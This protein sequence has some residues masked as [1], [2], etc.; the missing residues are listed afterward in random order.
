M[1]FNWFSK[2]LG[3]KQQSQRKRVQVDIPIEQH[4][5]RKAF[6]D[7]KPRQVSVKEDE[8]TN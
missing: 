5:Y 8:S 6:F 2:L 4:S 1:M 3:K 7:V